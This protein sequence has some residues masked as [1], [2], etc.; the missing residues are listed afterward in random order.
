MDVF[1]P[2]EYVIRRRLEKKKASTTSK[3]SYR[4]HSQRNDGYNR[5]E[6]TDNKAASS[7]SSHSPL[8]NKKGFGLLED[9]DMFTYFSV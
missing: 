2:E 7:S 4:S 6:V 8:S 5:I 3:R 1:I 9:N